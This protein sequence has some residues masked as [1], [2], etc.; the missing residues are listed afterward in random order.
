ML[1]RTVNLKRNLLFLQLSVFFP[2][3]ITFGAGGYLLYYLGF[4]N[5]YKIF[6][7]IGFTVEI[8]MAGRVYLS[9]KN[10]IK[11]SGDV[12]TLYKNGEPNSPIIKSFQT[13]SIKK[14]IPC[15][16]NKTIKILTYDNKEDYLLKLKYTKAAGEDVYFRIKSELCRFLPAKT[17]EMRNEYVSDYIKTGMTPEYIKNLQQ[18]ELSCGAVILFFEF[19]LAVIPAGMTI[20]SVIWSACGFYIIFLKSVVI[21]LNF[22]KYT[23]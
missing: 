5:W 18:T 1:D 14:V 13:I 10:A 2:I 12:I 22:F 9:N 11:F 6:M 20:I 16:R 19:L 3:V 17:V 15:E 8:F 23:L 4:G 21:L 7:T